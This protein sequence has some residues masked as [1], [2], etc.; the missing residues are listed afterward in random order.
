MSKSTKPHGEGEVQVMNEFSDQQFLKPVT[1]QSA[2]GKA[3]HEK[4]GKTIG[5]R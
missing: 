5:R 3:R 4:K 2:C 1:E